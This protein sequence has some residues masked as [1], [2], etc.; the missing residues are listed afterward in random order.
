M[1][2]ERSRASQTAH[3]VNALEDLG[4]N[5]TVDVQRYFLRALPPL[6]VGLRSD[7]CSGKPG[8]N[9]LS[10]LSC[11]GTTQLHLRHPRKRRSTTPSRIELAAS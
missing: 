4:R 1:R 3:L 7:Y 2:C 8:A 11:F 5:L 6:S 10:A 9:G